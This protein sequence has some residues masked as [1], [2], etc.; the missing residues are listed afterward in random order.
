MNKKEATK[1]VQETFD[2]KFNIKNYTSFLSNLFKSFSPKDRLIQGQYIKEAY[3]KYV[4]QYRILGSFED[5][6]ENKI[7]FL[8]VQLLKNTSLERA[9]T[10]QRNFVAEYLKTRQKDAALVAFLSPETNEWR[11]S[12]VKLEYS[13]E[14]KE[15]KLKTTEETNP[16]KR[17]SFL[18]GDH[19]G[20]HTVTT[21]FLDLLQIH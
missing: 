10:A 7:D 15:G 12:L 6:E 8:Q 13:I 16:A 2:G 20:S 18:I 3:R 5:S 14:V 21:R 17:W 9:R 19:E 11:F 4:S 1:I